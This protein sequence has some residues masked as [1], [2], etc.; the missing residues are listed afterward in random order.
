MAVGCGLTGFGS[1]LWGEFRSVL[2]VSCGAETSLYLGDILMAL[3]DM[4]EG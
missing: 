2:Y 4:Q 1:K 3:A